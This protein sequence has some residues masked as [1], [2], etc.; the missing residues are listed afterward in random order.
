MNESINNSNYI[1]QDIIIKHTSNNVERSSWLLL[2]FSML[3]QISS[4][5][6]FPSYN[7]ALG[8]W[9]VYCSFTRHGRATFGYI[10]FLI[11]S[12]LLDIIYCSI[13]HHNTGLYRFCLAMFV[14]CLFIKIYA[15][16]YGS[17]F[18]AAIGGPHIIEENINDNTASHYSS[19][20]GS[21]ASIGSV[22]GGY[23]PPQDNSQILSNSDIKQKGMNESDIY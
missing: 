21:N 5:Y 17:Q 10:L 20:A 12:C 23:Y 22:G 9:G 11:Y 13:N 18:F 4:I 19:L 15:L 14:I 7:I 2:L 6:S 1:D 16:Y 8:F 3:T